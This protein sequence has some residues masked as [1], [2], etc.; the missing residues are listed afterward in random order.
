MLGA[1]HTGLRCHAT[2]ETREQNDSPS[3]EL[4]PLAPMCRLGRHATSLATPATPQQ[5]ADPEAVRERRPPPAQAQAADREGEV[6][7]HIH[8]GARR[9]REGGTQPCRGSL[10]RGVGPC[11]GDGGV[12]TNDAPYEEP[13]RVT[14][15]PCWWRWR[16]RRPACSLLLGFEV[17][18]LGQIACPVEKLRVDA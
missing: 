4:I 5:T 3:P 6:L 14:W 16:R 9:A 8:Q 17:P 7:D 11:Y 2:K 18:Q 10:V 12:G 13:A 15:S 1:S